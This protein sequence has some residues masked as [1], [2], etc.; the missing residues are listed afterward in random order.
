VDKGLRTSNY[1]QCIINM[2]MKRVEWIVG[3]GNEWQVLGVDLA[4]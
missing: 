2:V 1:R 3:V 4:M